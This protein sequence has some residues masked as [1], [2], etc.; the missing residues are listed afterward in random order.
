LGLPTGHPEA[1]FFG[2]TLYP[3]FEKAVTGFLHGSSTWIRFG[4]SISLCPRMV[5][6]L[7]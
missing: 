2:P 4:P 5:S 6:Q 1:R 3:S 7:N